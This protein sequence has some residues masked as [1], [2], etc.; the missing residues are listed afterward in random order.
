[1]ISAR[2]LARVLVVGLALVLVVSLAACGSSKKKKTAASGATQ[3]TITIS[4]S[5]KKASYSPPSSVK[6][7]LVELR[8]TNNG[9]APHGA[10]LARIVGN[11]TAQEALKIIASN[12]AK[13]PAWLRA[14]G[15]IGVVDPGQTGTATVNLTAG[16]YLVVDA[17]TMNGPPGFAEF[18]VTAGTSGTLPATATTVTAANPGKD[19]YR[20]DISGPLKAGTSTL[21]F[22]SKGKNALHFI[23]AFR[24]TGNPSKAAIIKALKSNGKPP[25]FVDTKTF[26]DSAAL[27]GGKSQVTTYT[28][29]KPGTYVLWCPLKDRDGGKS[30]FEE[31]LLKTVTVK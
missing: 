18:N 6:G 21:T 28:F 2:S 20:W 5:G 16:R 11:H 14:E 30:H 9:K 8:A 25:S 15:G 3:L 31:G 26:T 7:G 1:V 23:G 17:G 24:V 29:S 10:Q 27:D 13:T 12:A 22:N 19:K 4:E